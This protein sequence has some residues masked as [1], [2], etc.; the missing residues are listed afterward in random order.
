MSNTVLCIEFSLQDRLLID[1]IS[2]PT[3]CLREFRSVPFSVFAESDRWRL[4]ITVGVG[5]TGPTGATGATGAEALFFEASLALE[6]HN[7]GVDNST[8]FDRWL[9]MLWKIWEAG[10]MYALSVPGSPNAKMP[11]RSPV[12]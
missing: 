9:C 12:S 8:F 3:E 5:G 4:G 1:D 6:S 2:S 7:S 11:Y 10:M